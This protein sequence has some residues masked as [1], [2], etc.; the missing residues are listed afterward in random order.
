MS[1]ARPMPVGFSE[2][3]QHTQVYLIEKYHCTQAQIRRWRMELGVEAPRRSNRRR[4]IWQIKDGLIIRRHTSV[5]A[6]ARSVG[7]DCPN[8]IKAAR[9][10]IKQ[11]YGYS[12]RY[13]NDTYGHQHGVRTEVR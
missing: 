9:G 2:D 5:R 3:H 11:A 6:A 10:E 12:W 13:V 4:A 8:I 7:G 1:L